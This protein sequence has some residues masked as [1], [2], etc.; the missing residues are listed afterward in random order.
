MDVVGTP[1]PPFYHLFNRSIMPTTTEKT[2][3][4]IPE[5]INPMLSI[6][7]AP[8]IRHALEEMFYAYVWTCTGRLEEEHEKI[9]FIFH[10]LVHL[11]DSSPLEN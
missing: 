1:A 6:A 2:T 3:T 4:K 5:P 9:C 7:D 11:L 10:G 8:E